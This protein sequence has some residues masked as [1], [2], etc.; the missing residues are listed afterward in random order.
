[1]SFTSWIDQQIID[2]EKRGVFD[3][4]PGAGKPIPRRAQD[5][6]G[7]GW[8][9]DYLRREGVS[10]EELLPTPLKLRKDVERLAASVENLSSEQEVR[11]AVAELN[12]RIIDWRRT[13]AGQPIFVSLVNEELMVRKW[14]AGQSVKQFAPAPADADCETRDMPPARPGWW[15]RLSRFRRH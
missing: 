3:N 13:S 8:L 2:A 11:D 14:T 7:Q 10:A 4:L 5:A 15:R 6:D 9:R 1:M 12:R